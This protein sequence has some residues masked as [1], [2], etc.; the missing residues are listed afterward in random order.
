M[1]KCVYNGPSGD[2][3]RVTGLINIEFMSLSIAT[4][5]FSKVAVGME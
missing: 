4:A 3:T 5:C 2:K 1:G